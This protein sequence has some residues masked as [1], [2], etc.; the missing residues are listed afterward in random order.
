MTVKKRKFEPLCEPQKNHELDN[1]LLSMRVKS[2]FHLVSLM[3][4]LNVRPA[5][6]LVKNLQELAKAIAKLQ[7]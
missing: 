6:E 5:P 3:D 4:S 2:L 7:R 1:L